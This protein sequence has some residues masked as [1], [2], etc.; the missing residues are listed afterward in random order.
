MQA[1]IFVF[2]F[3]FILI[4]HCSLGRKLQSIR[5]RP[6][7][8]LVRHEVDPSC[9]CKIAQTSHSAQSLDNQADM[10]AKVGT[11]WF[12]SQTGKEWRNYLLSE[13][14]G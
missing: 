4:V 9:G 1:Q 3:I 2:V 7:I 6:S 12:A 13:L 11:S 5:E 8:E 14:P 10:A